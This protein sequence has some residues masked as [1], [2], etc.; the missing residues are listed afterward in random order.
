ML[1]AALVAVTEV[2]A[3]TPGVMFCVKSAQGVYLSANAAFAT[4]VGVDGPGEV[5]GRS[6]HDLFPAE[7][8]DQYVAQDEEILASGRML[9]NE[10][11]LITQRDGSYGWFVTSKSRWLEHGEPAGLVSVSVDLRAP[12]AAAGPH[13]RLA[14]AVDVARS[15]CADA[16]TV[17]EMASAAEMS[18]AQ[19]ERATRKT[20]GLTPKRLI[21]RFRLEEALRLLDTTDQSLAEIAVQCGY[22]DQ[23]TFSRRFRRVVGWSPAAWRRRGELSR[24]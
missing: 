15:R 16:L 20:L 23:A 6:A 12:D 1:N 4:R 9:S 3:T 11:E 8:A 21:L 17:A 14:A 2:L 18:V 24:R 22:Y 7:L 10:L 5:V 13:P 19:L